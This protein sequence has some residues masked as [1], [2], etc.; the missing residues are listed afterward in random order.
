VARKNLNATI[1]QLIQNNPYNLPQ[2]ADPKAYELIRPPYSF[3]N[4]HVDDRLAL[5]RVAP[6]PSLQTNLS[7]AVDIAFENFHKGGREFPTSGSHILVRPDLKVK[8]VVDG[9]GI[10][11]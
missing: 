2:I 6:F 5:K 11:N 1:Q 7:K 3:Y 4:Q 10:F 8:E 9:R